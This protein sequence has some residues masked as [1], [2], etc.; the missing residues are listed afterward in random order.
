MIKKYQQ[1]I[2]C[3][4]EQLVTR[5]YD[6]GVAHSFMFIPIAAMMEARHAYLSRAE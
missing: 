3:F 4:F 6:S 2:T 1:V 5:R